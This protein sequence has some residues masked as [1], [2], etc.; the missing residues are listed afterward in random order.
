MCGDGVPEG[1]EACDPGPGHNI[2]CNQDCTLSVC[3]DGKENYEF[4]D[5]DDGNGDNTDSCVDGCFFAECG[6]GYVWAGGEECDDANLDDDDG[7]SNDCEIQLDPCGH[8]ME[9][10]FAFVQWE[11]KEAPTVGTAKF[12]SSSGSEF[13]WKALENSGPAQ[14]DGGQILT[15]GFPPY[16]VVGLQI[17][18]GWDDSHLYWGT[19]PLQS[20]SNATLCIVASLSNSEVPGEM[21]LQTNGQKAIIPLVGDPSGEA[22]FP[23]EVDLGTMIKA[24]EGNQHL[25]LKNPSNIPTDLVKFRYARIVFHDPVLK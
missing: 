5:C 10:N 14:F 4:E 20:Y 13:D 8:P 22:L 17:F 9:G 24:G 25:Y 11:W 1:S 18:N 12:K 7:C 2:Y 15:L 6:D 23:V 3:G 19:T 16:H 21:W